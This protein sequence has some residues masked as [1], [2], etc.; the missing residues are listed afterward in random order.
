LLGST[1]LAAVPTDSTNLRNALTVENIRA[2]QQ[3][4][5]E[6]ADENDGTRASGTPGYDDSAGYVAAQLE[7]AGYDVTR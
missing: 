3:A 4:L 6:I 5:Q 7:A 2:H 1:A